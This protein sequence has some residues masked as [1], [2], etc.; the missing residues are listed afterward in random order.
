MGECLGIVNDYSRT[1]MLRHVWCFVTPK[2]VAR[3]S[4]LSTEFFRHEYWSGL[5]FPP[6]EDLPDPRI[7][8]LSPMSLASA[9]AF[10]TA[11]PPGKLIMT[12]FKHYSQNFLWM[13]VLNPY[14]SGYCYSHVKDEETDTESMILSFLSNF[15]NLVAPGLSCGMWDLGPCSGTESL[16]P[17]LEARSLSP[18]LPGKFWTWAV[19]SRPH[20]KRLNWD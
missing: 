10:F 18:G 15:V 19:Y 20:S 7:E 9:G 13:N 16:P 11:E 3:Q 1:C 14:K 5:P 8:T 2:P 12:V 6:P 17:V 4:S